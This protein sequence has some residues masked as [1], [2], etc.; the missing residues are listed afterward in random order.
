MQSHHGADFLILLERSAKSAATVGRPDGRRRG[1][2]PEERRGGFRIVGCP[3][4][5]A[6]R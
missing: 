5:R 6:A 1:W 3:L 2:N 4:P